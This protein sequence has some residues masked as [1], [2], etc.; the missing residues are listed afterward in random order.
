MAATCSKYDRAL[1]KTLLEN[2]IRYKSDLENTKKTT[3]CWYK[4]SAD[5]LRFLEQRIE[6]ITNFIITQE[7]YLSDDTLK[8]IDEK[9][10][11]ITIDN[12]RFVEKNINAIN[13]D[14]AT[15]EKIKSHLDTL[16]DSNEIRASINNLKHDVKPD[17]KPSKK[18]E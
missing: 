5:V 2:L 9:I 11:T 4:K 17:I 18:I 14:L 13:N 8:D 1:I 10:V 15:L 16:P 3:G 12:Y 7:S 6:N